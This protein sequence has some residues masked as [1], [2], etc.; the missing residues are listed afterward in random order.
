[1][2]LNGVIIA[3]ASKAGRILVMRR[4]FLVLQSTCRL[5]DLF[6]LSFIQQPAST[7]TSAGLS[8]VSI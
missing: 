7:E 1:M 6:N 8:L 3:G 5:L 2:N 4:R